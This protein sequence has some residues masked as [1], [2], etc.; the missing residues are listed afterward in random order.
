MS[1]VK[2]VQDDCLDFMNML[3]KVYL[4][5]VCNFDTLLRVDESF[6]LINRSLT[7]GK[8]EAMFYYIDGFVKDGVMQ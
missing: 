3:S 5:N 6:D 2:F 7:I 1:I 4:E 8:D